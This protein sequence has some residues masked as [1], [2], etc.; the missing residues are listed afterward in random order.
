MDAHRDPRRRSRVWQR[1]KRQVGFYI[2][3]GGPVDDVR[4]PER[5]ATTL[6]I[7][8]ATE[9]EAKGVCA[10][11]RARGQGAHGLS[12]QPR[13]LDLALEPFLS[14]HVCAWPLVQVCV[15]ATTFS[16][17]AVTALAR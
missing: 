11:W 17:P 1:L 2:E 6:N 8:H 5:E 14:R 7:E 9:G 13:R 10:V 15:R 3:H 4:A 16:G 12:A